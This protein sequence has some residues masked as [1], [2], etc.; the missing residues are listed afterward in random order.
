MSKS[1]LVSTS[2]HQKVRQFSENTL[3]LPSRTEG[4]KRAFP[5][6]RPKDGEGGKTNHGM[7]GKLPKD[8]SAGGTQGSYRS[9]AERVG[10]NQNQPSLLIFKK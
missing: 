7:S 10:A 6:E 2:R 5:A 1:A 3:E 8:C 4:R 9:E